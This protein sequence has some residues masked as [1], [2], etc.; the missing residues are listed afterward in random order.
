MAKKS[1]VTNTT[2]RCWCN[3]NEDIP[4]DSISEMSELEIFAKVFG[5]KTMSEKYAVV[6]DD[7]YNDVYEVHVFDSHNSAAS[8]ISRVAWN[9]YQKAI[10]KYGENAVW[11]EY[12]IDFT[13]AY[14]SDLSKDWEIELSV[15]KVITH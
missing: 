9:E 4:A 12:F 8:F 2:Y 1:I 5:E 13:Y 10:A 15:T 7:T 11:F 6:Y 3:A 14:I